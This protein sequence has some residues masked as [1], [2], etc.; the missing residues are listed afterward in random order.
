MS[1]ETISKRML[2]GTVIAGLTFSTVELF[3]LDEADLNSKYL[4]GIFLR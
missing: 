1:G 4:F 2:D 3:S